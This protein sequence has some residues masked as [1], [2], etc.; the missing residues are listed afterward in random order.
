MLS[1]VLSPMLMPWVNGGLA[2]LAAVSLT[3]L[4]QWGARKG[5]WVA[6]PEAG[7]WHDTPTTLLGGVAIVLAGAAVLALGGQAAFPILVWAGAGL[8]FGAGLVDDL[9]GL[10]PVAKLIAQFGSA[11]LALSAGLLFAPSAPVWVSVPLTL[12]WLLGLPNAL[13]LLDAMDGVAAS[14]TV[15]AAAFLGGVAGLQ[16]A[17][18]LATAA[19]VLAGATAGFLVFNVPP[20]R[21]F[22][23]DCGSLVLG[24][25]L[26]V[27]GMGVQSSVGTATSVLVPVLILA[28]PIFDTTFVS[29]T[30]IRR[31]ESVT[32]GGTDHTMHRLARLQWS[33]R[34]VPLLLCGGGI[35]AGGI[36]LVGQVG[37][38][39]LFYTLVL[40]GVATAVGIGRL[41]AHRTP[42]EP[43]E[44]PRP[45]PTH[46]TSVQPVPESKRPAPRRPTT[47]S[48]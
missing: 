20:A 5:G 48:R 38:P 27:L 18:A 30:R 12:I 36:G 29:I 35:L 39:L 31:G 43:I 23:G 22:M 46:T 1:E 7:K 24:Y 13:N 32:N 47:P 33:E 9:W 42:P 28:V 34:Q 6:I 10:G 44:T 25:M 21:I 45:A 19:A 8:L 26:A 3:P 16:G 4:V 37:P 40:G 41:L 11:A 2:V 14:V 15:L 17:W